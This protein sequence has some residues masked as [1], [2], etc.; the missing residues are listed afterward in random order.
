[1]RLLLR[2]SVISPVCAL[3]S[4]EEVHQ[5]GYSRALHPAGR[6]ERDGRWRLAD[7]E[8]R[9][10]PHPCARYKAA[11]PGGKP[12]ASAEAVVAAAEEF[13]QAEVSEDLELLANFVAH[14]AVVGMQAG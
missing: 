7:S 2:P 1:L 6:F 3:M 12:M 8:A 5:K 10:N 14:M 11:A 13:E 9:K 4:R